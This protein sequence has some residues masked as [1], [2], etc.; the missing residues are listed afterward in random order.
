ADFDAGVPLLESSRLVIELASAESAV[1]SLIAKLA[2]SDLAGPLSTY[3]RELITDLNSNPDV[4]GAAFATG[5][6]T[7]HPRHGVLRFVAWTV[8]VR[9]L[10]PVL[11]D[12][13]CWRDDE[14]WLRNICPACG[15]KPAM[16]QL[17]GNDPGRLRL[18]AC[19]CCR[20]RWRYRRTAC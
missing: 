8:L 2:S 5:A 4:L 3:C 11:E 7:A 16:A 12:F 6:P 20:T 17:V 1:I 10:Q 15:G 18:L 19:G 13:A 9:Y 14:R